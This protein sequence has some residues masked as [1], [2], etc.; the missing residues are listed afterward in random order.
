MTPLLCVGGKQ[1]AEQG[2][3]SQDFPHAGGH[4]RRKQTLRPIH[5]REVVGR[6][7]R[8]THFIERVVG[9][10][11]HPIVGQGRST[12]RVSLAGHR[13]PD[14]DQT[15]GIR[16]RQRPQQH[17]RNDTEERGGSTDAEREDRHRNRR[18]CGAPAKTSNGVPQVVGEVFS[19]AQRPCVAATLLGLSQSP[20]IKT[21]PADGF[22]LIDADVSSGPRLHGQVK[23][24]FVVEI[25][26][27]PR[28]ANNR[29]QSDRQGGNPAWQVHDSTRPNSVT[30]CQA[31]FIF[32]TAEIALASRSQLALSRSRCFRPGRVSS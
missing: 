4:A 22:G 14:A 29:A 10:P 27:R 12:S 1:S 2:P 23:R 7:V 17:G 30:R 18:K 31:S 11:P 21:R 9:G 6:I 5:S 26:L 20:Q 8:G 32:T 15:V 28:A 24:Q 25:F 13:R 16:V 3:R 19:P